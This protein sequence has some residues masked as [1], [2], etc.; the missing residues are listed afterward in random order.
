MWCIASLH[1]ASLGG[2]YRVWCVL[3]QLDILLQATY[4]KLYQGKWWA[5]LVAMIS[6]LRR[7]QTLVAEMGSVCPKTSTTR[8][9]AMFLATFWITEHLHEIMAHYAEMPAVRRASDPT[10]VV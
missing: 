5:T 3:H 2:F 8:W 4:Q 9:H 10:S 6:H 1:Q 7:Q